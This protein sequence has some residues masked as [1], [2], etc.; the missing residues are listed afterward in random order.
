LP[1][2][3]GEYFYPHPAESQ[4]QRCSKSPQFHLLVKLCSVK[5]N[6]CTASKLAC[7]VD[8]TIRV[9]TYIHTYKFI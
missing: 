2:T 6:N 7:N 5:D 9:R 4:A 3:L 1:K 8:M